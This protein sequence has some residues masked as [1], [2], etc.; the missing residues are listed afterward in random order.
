MIYEVDGLMKLNLKKSVTYCFFISLVTIIVGFFLW[1]IL[2]PHQDAQSQTQEELKRAQRMLALNYPL[3]RFL[4]YTGFF[5]LISSSAYFVIN[6]LKFLL[7]K[8]K[9]RKK[10]E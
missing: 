4:L 6:G 1:T 8:I 3:G 7:D 2:I 5:G 10:I 9:R